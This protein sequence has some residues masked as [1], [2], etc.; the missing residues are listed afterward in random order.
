VNDAQG[1]SHARTRAIGIAGAIAVVCALSA[2]ACGQK[3]DAE[4]PESEG[5]LTPFERQLRQV[6]DCAAQPRPLGDYPAGTA[7]EDIV[8][9]VT[10]GDRERFAA[11][12]RAPGFQSE[13]VVLL[14]IEGS[15]KT[16]LP[17]D[18]RVSRVMVIASDETEGYGAQINELPVQHEGQSVPSFQ[19]QF[20]GRRLSEIGL[21]G[22]CPGGQI[23]AI[24]GATTTS[25][26]VVEAARQAAGRIIARTRQVYPSG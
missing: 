6:L 11:A 24:T 9:A 15:P 2:T 17:A 23:A 25:R 19:L 7:A 14:S 16:A 12:G 10:V 22:E 26:A 20:W 4:A 5:P 18:P 13:I 1:I 8:Y 3:K 21:E